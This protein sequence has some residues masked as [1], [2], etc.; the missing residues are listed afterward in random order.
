LGLLLHG[1]P[2]T[3]KTS[4]IKAV[5]HY[6]G[7]THYTGRNIVNIN[8]A[9]IAINAALHKIILNKMYQFSS[10]DAKRLDFDQLMF[11]FED[12]DAGAKEVVMD[13]NMLA[14][15]EAEKASKKNYKDKDMAEDA[16]VLYRR[17]SY[18]R[19]D[20][21]SKDKLNLSGLLNVLDGVVETPGRIIIFTTNCPEMMDPALI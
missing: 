15:I 4:L 6:T 7:R 3:G 14:K 2:G 12:I 20:R 1:E 18:G 9:N 19:S 16:A 13:R 17:R 11:V 21:E 5:A 10:G 8:L